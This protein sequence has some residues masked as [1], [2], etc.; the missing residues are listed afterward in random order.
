MAGH[1]AFGGRT[2]GSVILYGLLFIG[3]GMVFGAG[4]DQVAKVF[5]LPILGVILL[6]EALALSWLARDVASSRREFPIALLVGLLAAGLPYGYV[7][8]LVVGTLLYYLGG[9]IKLINP[10]VL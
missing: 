7:I 2:G 9:R 8:G 6:F 1:F 4:F 10:E 5:P 3:L